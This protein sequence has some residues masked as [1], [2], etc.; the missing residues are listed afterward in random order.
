MNFF[1]AFRVN[2]S[3][4]FPAFYLTMFGNVN[5][6]CPTFFAV[7]GPP[8]PPNPIL[9]HVC[10]HTY[11]MM[12]YWPPN[13][14]KIGHH[15]CTFPLGKKPYY[16]ETSCTKDRKLINKKNKVIVLEF[17]FLLGF[18]THDMFLFT[19]FFSKL[20]LFDG[21]FGPPAGYGFKMVTLL[22]YVPLIHS[23]PKVRSWPNPMG[24]TPNNWKL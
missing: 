6:W 9:S 21:W 23:K 7:F 24:S 18:E 8:I 2:S 13:P 10:W 1:W 4:H 22:A 15:L 16:L 14:P 11:F 5:K 17:Y 12:S 3:L 19:I 20:A